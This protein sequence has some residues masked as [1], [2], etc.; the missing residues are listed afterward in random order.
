MTATGLKVCHWTQYNH[1][2][3]NNVAVSLADAEK[4]LGLNSFI[5]N[6]FEEH[7]WDHALDADVHVAHTWFP[8]LYNG[9]SFRRQL[10]KPQKI[11][12]VY[13]GTPENIFLGDVQYAQQ[14]RAELNAGFA[15][16]HSRMGDGSMLLAYWLRNADAHVT[17]WGRHHAL[18]KTQVERNTIVD[19]IP[20]GVDRLWWDSAFNVQKMAGNP[21]LWSGENP[22]PIKFP[23]DLVEAWPLVYPHL[24]GASLYLDYLGTDFH[25]QFAP[26]ISR[27][28]AGYGMHWS[29]IKW[30]HGVLR[31]LFRGIDY[32]IGL[33]RY[34]DFNMLS[35]QANAAGAKTIS[36]PGNPYSDYWV[37]EG[38]HRLLAADLV[39]IL[40]GEVEARQKDE[41]PDIEETARAMLPIYER[42]LGRPVWR[43]LEL[44]PPTVEH[45]EAGAA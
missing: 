18:L 2:G 26:L 35:H 27:N 22:H 23:L 29:D 28:G 40:K 39:K 8:E 14:K 17:F 10:T 42:I 33:V 41:V 20:L 36:Y 34:G 5:V 24:D 13:H 12:S 4:R 38:D 9:K 43:G 15:T 7:N 1:S 19:L 32:F 30:S 37:H 44:V 21:S 11:V 45:V 31:N 25:R 16:P 6:C 3:M